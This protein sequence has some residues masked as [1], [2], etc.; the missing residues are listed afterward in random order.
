MKRILL[1]AA[2]GLVLSTA[3]LGD[4]CDG[5][6]KGGYGPGPGM[7]GGYGGGPHGGWDGPGMMGGG[8]MGFGPGA[9]GFDRLDLSAEQRDKLAGIMRESRAKQFKV[10]EQ[11]HEQAWAQAGSKDGKFDE[12]AARKAYDAREKLHRQ[13]FENRL[14]LRKQVDAVLTPEQR[15]KL[16]RR[17]GPG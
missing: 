10:M 6:P 13:M 1:A 9:Y 12:A 15:E 4:S 2:T 16:G 11:M 5:G 17:P 14:E 3:A 8:M 7:M